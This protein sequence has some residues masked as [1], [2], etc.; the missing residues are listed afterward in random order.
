[1]RMRKTQ[2][3]C[4]VIFGETTCCIL[5]KLMIFVQMCLVLTCYPYY[6]CIFF[7]RVH[8]SSRSLLTCLKQRMRFSLQEVLEEVFY[9]PG[10]LTFWIECINKWAHHIAGLKYFYANNSFCLYILFV[11]SNLHSKT[12][13]LLWWVCRHFLIYFIFPLPF[14]W[15]P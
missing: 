14:Q 6:E 13:V 11:S 10:H 4:I 3:I 2:V 8:A 7:I 1:M 9:F 5:R 15:F 12:A